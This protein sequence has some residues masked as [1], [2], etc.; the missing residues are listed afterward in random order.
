MR[1]G[2][3]SPWNGAQRQ[4]GNRNRPWATRFPMP[5]YPHFAMGC[6]VCGL[7][8]SK[9][10]RSRQGGP[11]GPGRRDHRRRDR[12]G[13]AHPG[14]RAMPPWTW[15]RGANDGDIA[16]DRASHRNGKP[17]YPLF[18]TP[19]PSSAAASRWTQSTT[20]PPVTNHQRDFTEKN[21][22]LDSGWGER[23]CS[24]ERTVPPEGGH[25][26]REGG[27]ENHAVKDDSFTPAGA[28]PSFIPTD[29]RPHRERLSPIP[30]HGRRTATERHAST[31][32]QHSARRQGGTRRVALPQQRIMT[33]GV[34]GSTRN[35]TRC[36]SRFFATTRRAS[37]STR[38]R[39]PTLVQTTTKC[40]ATDILGKHSHL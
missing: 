28:G 7:T 12:A 25:A 1:T 11:P 29:C 32:R 26:H 37:P 2:A 23:P 15:R 5:L 40:V 34:T 8:C 27:D 36:P 20:R 16:T 6:G 38:N 19:W 22:R 30:D 3:S 21:T 18:V 9:E 24:P 17:R 31:S 13:H 39:V 10:E 14:R 35:G 33:R 4:S